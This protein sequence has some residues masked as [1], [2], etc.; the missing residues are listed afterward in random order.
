[1][2][3]FILPVS[4]LLHFFIKPT[5]DPIV[6]LVLVNCLI[7]L[8]DHSILFLITSHSLNVCTGSGVA[9]KCVQPWKYL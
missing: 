2:C 8:T 6:I 9:W 1:M 4:S 5:S 7:N 3:L